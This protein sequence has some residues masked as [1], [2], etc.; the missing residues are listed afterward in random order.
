MRSAQSSLAAP[1]PLS[2]PSPQHDQAATGEFAPQRATLGPAIAV[3]VALLGFLPIANWIPGGHAAPWYRDV[4]SGWVS[5]TAIAIGVGVVLAILSGR[6]DGLWRDG[7]TAA[8]C[9][10]FE[11]RPWTVTRASRWSPCS[12][13]RTWR[14]ACWV[15]VR[16]SSMSWCRC[17]KRERYCARRAV[18]AGGAAPGIFQQHA[19]GGHARQSVLAVS[20]R[21]SGRAHGR[22]AAR[23]A[24]GGRTALRRDRR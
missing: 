14:C 11:Q 13:T 16:S 4:A 10:A 21:R 9:E 6:W 15:D 2:V 8:P 12:R 17:S 23:G 19:R 24:V 1:S 5:G 20:G 7:I 3:L 18:D 22:R